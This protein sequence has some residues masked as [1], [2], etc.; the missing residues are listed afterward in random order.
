LLYSVEVLNCQS[1]QALVR[2]TDPL[3][4]IATKYV[5]NH[6]PARLSTCRYRLKLNYL[7]G[8]R[9]PA[10][11]RARS[12]LFGVRDFGRAIVVST[13]EGNNESPHAAFQKRLE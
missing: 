13:I 6:N 12:F 3:S 8:N 9:A 7:L 2:A 11:A 4:A 5:S 1:T 10:Q